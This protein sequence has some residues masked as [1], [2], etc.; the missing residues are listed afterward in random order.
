[1][2]PLQEKEHRCGVSWNKGSNAKDHRGRRTGRVIRQIRKGFEVPFRVWCN[3]HMVFEHWHNSGR[4]TKELCRYDAGP[5]TQFHL[6]RQ[7]ANKY[8]RP[9]ALAKTL[10]RLFS[11]TTTIQSESAE[12]MPQRDHLNI[13]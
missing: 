2:M 8:C 12:K 6:P 7:A 4:G 11:P 10:G 13:A 5:A 1:M 3:N 9:Y